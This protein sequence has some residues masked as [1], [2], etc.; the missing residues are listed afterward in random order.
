MFKELVYLY[1]FKKVCQICATRLTCLIFRNLSFFKSRMCLFVTYL[2]SHRHRQTSRYLP[3]AA[4]MREKLIRYRQETSPSLHSSLLSDDCWWWRKLVWTR[5]HSNSLHS[6][7]GYSNVH[8][9]HR[10]LRYLTTT[11]PGIWIPVW[12]LDLRTWGKWTSP[13][14]D[15]QVSDFYL[16]MINITALVYIIDGETWSKETL[17][18][19][20]KWI[21]IAFRYFRLAVPLDRQVCF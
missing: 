8:R 17:W 13:Q 18:T 10:S 9:P 19:H 20:L 16:T 15:E 14:E 4:R 12:S 6:T 5:F 3:Q 11:T 1:I 7:S 21:S 2:Q